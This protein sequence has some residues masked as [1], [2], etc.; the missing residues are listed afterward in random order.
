M[1]EAELDFQEQ[2]IPR[3]ASAAFTAAFWHAL[4]AGQEVVVARDGKLIKIYPDGR[5]EFLKDI[6]KRISVRPGVILKLT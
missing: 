4:A 1:T 3:L 2:A 6:E 5:E